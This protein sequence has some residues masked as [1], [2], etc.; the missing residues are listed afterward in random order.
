VILPRFDVRQASANLNLYDGMTVIF[1]K[2]RSEITVGG[3]KVDDKPKVENKE[4]LV[5]ITVTLVD[6]T[7]NRI[8]SDDEMPFAKNGIQPQP[9]N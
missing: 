8:H 7:G 2:I 9:N 3:K 6:P 5:F 1:R 4:L